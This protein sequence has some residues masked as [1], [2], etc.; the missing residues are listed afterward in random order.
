[1]SKK[2]QSSGDIIKHQQEDLHTE[3]KLLYSLLSKRVKLPGGM[4][5][6]N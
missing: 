1:M 3:M 6:N 5:A 4:W 2:R